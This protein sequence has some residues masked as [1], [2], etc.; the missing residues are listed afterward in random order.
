MFCSLL[1]MLDISD[2]VIT[3][4]LIDHRRIEFV[5]LCE[6]KDEA[7]DT[8]LHNPPPNY[9]EMFTM[10]GD[11]MFSWPCF[12]S[13][14]C[15]PTSARYLSADV[16]QLIRQCHSDR[17][18]LNATLHEKTEDAAHTRDRIR[19]KTEVWFL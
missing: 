17:S 11:Q 13:Y 4:C 19:R 12:R 3:N 6:S 1:Q 10:N 5:L 16:E 8:M 14:L 18:R 9:T 15:K 7:T 2:P